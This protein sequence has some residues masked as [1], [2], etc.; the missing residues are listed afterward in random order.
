MQLEEQKNQTLYYSNFSIL[1]QDENKKL[2]KY[3]Y[4]KQSLLMVLGK[5]Y[6]FP[7]IH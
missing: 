4:I 5:N 2:I 7:I 3:F 6:N 1:D